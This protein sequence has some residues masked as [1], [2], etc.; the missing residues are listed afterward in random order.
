MKLIYIRFL[1]IRIVLSLALFGCG[2]GGGGEGVG[3]SDSSNTSITPTVVSGTVDVNGGLIEVTDPS[4]PIFGAKV[5]VPPNA[6][7]QNESIV[8][9]LS[10]QDNLPKPLNAANAKEVSKVIVLSKSDPKNFLKPVA[11]TIPYTAN[12]LNAGDAPAVFYFDTHYD[13]YVSAGVEEID[14]VAKFITFKTVHFSRFVAVGIAGLASDLPGTET[15]FLPGQDG[16][17]HPNFGAYEH[18]GGSSLGMVNYSQWY[19]SFKRNEDGEDLYYK[20]REKVYDA[21]QDDVTAKELISRSF[22]CARQ[23]WAQIYLLSDYLMGEYNTALLLL[24][25]LTVT[26]MPQTL[27]FTGEERDP[28][29]NTVTAQWGHAVTVYKYES[30]K[31]YI[32]DSNFPGEVV[33][34]D[35]DSFNGFHNYSKEAAY[36]GSNGKITKWG[37]EAIGDI[38]EYKEF[39][40]IYDGAENGWTSSKFVTITVTNPTLD[41]D[42]AAVIGNSDNLEVSGTVSGAEMQATHIFYSLNGGGNREDFDLVD[43]NTGEFRFIIPYLPNP[44]NTVTL[45]ATADLNNYFRNIPHSYA[46]FKELTLKIQ[47]LNFF[48]NIGFETGDFSG[49]SHETHTWQDQTAGS[50]TPEKSQI[51]SSGADQFIPLIQKVYHGNYSFRVNDFLD[52]YHISSVSQSRT[53]PTM[54]NPTLEFYWAAVLEDPQHPPHA[55]PYIELEVVNETSGNTL[56]YKHFYSND[57]SYSGWINAGHGSWKGIPW[58]KVIV[59]LGNSIGDTVRL[60]VL[61]ADCGL[62]GHGGY[63]YLDGLE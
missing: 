43:P 52:R 46:G 44:T 34:L 2:G 37:F 60:K 35:W 10:Y 12:E 54:T 32:Y 45:I 49:W 61:A 23:R 17:F 58:Q 48:T 42:D 25:T 26:K 5:Q 55:Q 3:N 11:V 40:D 18:P 56:Y 14:T 31:F 38:F 57:P 13:T 9:T 15:G 41:T 4:N 39:E 27:C 21:W 28:Q 7:D 22:Y 50:F 36:I 33:T 30:G 1:V 59:N 51:V 6:V 20:Y 62:G 63:V 29:T 53:V 16:F 8:I 19:Y 24:T 47:G